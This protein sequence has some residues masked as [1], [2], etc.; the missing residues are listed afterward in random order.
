MPLNED[1]P[2]LSAITDELHALRNRMRHEDVYDRFTSL[3]R[4]RHLATSLIVHQ[5]SFG[6]S[7]K[8]IYRHTH[9][10]LIWPEYDLIKQNGLVLPS[11]RSFPHV[12][13]DLE[14][15]WTR[16]RPG[17]RWGNAWDAKKRIE[18]WLTNGESVAL[19]AGKFRVFNSGEANAISQ[20]RRK[21]KRLVVAVASN[22]LC[23]VAQEFAPIQ[24]S[25]FLDERMQPLVDLT[26]PDGRKIDYVFH[27]DADHFFLA[28]G[29]TV[30]LRWTPLSTQ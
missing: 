5:D 29:E 25:P 16:V 19:I 11:P 6:V 24:W 20:L 18:E 23:G 21:A 7:D 9:K 1:R 14:E 22:D 8:T 15:G 28:H 4:A 27:N 12:E 10:F 13:S 17:P 2:S 3:R 26:F 30:N